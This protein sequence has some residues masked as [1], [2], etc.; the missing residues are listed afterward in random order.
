MFAIKSYL[1]AI[2]IQLNSIPDR[3]QSKE[4]FLTTELDAWIELFIHALNLSYMHHNFWLL[5]FQ[6]YPVVLFCPG[7]C[8]VLM[9]IGRPFWVTAISCMADRPGGFLACR[10][11]GPATPFALVFWC[12]SGVAPVGGFVSSRASPWGCGPPGGLGPMFVPPAFF[13][14]ER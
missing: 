5:R 14:V 8:V 11:F 13:G 9:W 12:G 3:M 4:V 10:G 7:C 2:E 6:M 1:F